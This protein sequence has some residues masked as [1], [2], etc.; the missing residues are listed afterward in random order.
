MNNYERI[1]NFSLNRMADF[2]L[3]L[4]NYKCSFPS[5]Y[6][7]CEGCPAQYI[8]TYEVKTN[9]YAIKKWLQQESR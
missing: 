6:H 1:K 9:K 4:K 7:Y 2:L 5:K 3:C 8:C